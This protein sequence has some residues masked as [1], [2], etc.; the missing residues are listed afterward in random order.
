MKTLQDSKKSGMLNCPNCNGKSELYGVLESGYFHYQCL[1]CHE[2]FLSN[3]FYTD[4]LELL[5][6]KKLIYRKKR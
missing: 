4:S 6:N 1:D 2:Q 5:K 3:F